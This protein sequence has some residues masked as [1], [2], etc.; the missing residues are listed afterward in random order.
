MMGEQNVFCMVEMMSQSIEPVDLEVV[1]DDGHDWLIRYHEH[2]EITMREMSVI[3]VATIEDA[4]RKARITL[5]NDTY[6]IIAA[7][8][9]DAD[10]LAD[11]MTIP[12]YNDVMSIINQHDSIIRKDTHDA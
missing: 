7:Q 2:G 12:A 9:V 3:G 4:I 5:G 1:K 6:D 10:V 8:R 11:G